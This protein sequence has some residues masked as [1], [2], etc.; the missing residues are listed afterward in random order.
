M[1]IEIKTPQANTGG[2]DIAGA[3]Q[4]HNFDLVKRYAKRYDITLEEAEHL[5][6]ECRKFLVI[7]AMI[8]GPCSPSNQLDEMW[9]HFILH[10]R[11]YR[12]FC[13]KF[14]GRFIHHN[15]TETPSTANRSLML[16]TASQIFGYDPEIWP[17]V[18][19]T[20]CSSS[21]NDSYC[22]D[23]PCDNG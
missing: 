2:V 13:E 9:H 15:P 7:C 16:E 14:F 12:Q 6:T 10:T 8:S 5:F 19:K 17:K 1:S 11:D 18:G 3:L 22:D 4:Y 20:D 21:C 23:A